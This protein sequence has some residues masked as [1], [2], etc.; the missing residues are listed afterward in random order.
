MAAPQEFLCPITMNIMQDPVVGPD[1]HTYE[2]T[3]IVDWL[4]TS[5]QNQSPMTREPMT[6]DQLKP[7]YALRTSIERWISENGAIPQANASRPITDGE[8][9]VLVLAILDT[10]GSMEESATNTNSAEGLNFTRLDL[11]QHSM[12]TVASMLNQKDNTYMGIIKFSTNAER[13]L[14][15]TLMNSVGLGM[16][17]QAISGLRTGGSTNIWDGLRLALEDIQTIRKHKPKIHVEMILLTDGEPVASLNPPLGIVNTFKRA[18]PDSNANNIRLNTFGFGYRLDTNLLGDLCEEGSG[19]YGYIPDCS[20]V[21]TVFINY[22]SHI[23]TN[24]K[25][26]LS[27]EDSILLNG[28][29]DK[30]SQIY[31]TNVSQ[32]E[33]EQA[34]G[35]LNLIT[36]W[37]KESKQTPLTQLLLQ[38]VEDPDENKGQ[39]SKAVS[40]VDWFSSWGKNHILSYS[41][42]LKKKVCVNFKD[43]VLQEFMNDEFKQI[44]EKGN[45]LFAALPAPVPRGHTRESFQATGFTMN[46]FNTAAGGCFLGECM[47]TLKSGMQKRVDKI[48]KGDILHNNSVVLCVVERKVEKETK[49]VILPGGLTITPWH[50][51]RPVREWVFPCLFMNRVTM[52]YVDKFYDFVLV[53]EGVAKIDGY[54]VATLGHGMKDNGV[55]QHQ[56]YG[57]GA[58]VEDLMKQPGWSIGYIRM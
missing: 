55:V 17:N 5:G 12:R 58:V 50:P 56:Y 36:L 33:L 1:G 35:Y 30:L 29:A 10:S 22:C 26:E 15:P 32:T 48:V 34:R 16:A 46:M 2:R 43:L 24:P 25:V 3:A 37:V 54:D 51:I 44:Q 8:N 19:I 31:K 21:A 57:T 42:A 18:L 23:L 14:R 47:V 6:V 39:L 9:E 7:N 53:G 40:R 38:D 11:V 20:M 45:D 52:M 49:M 28:V 41:R 13:V 27:E 4:T